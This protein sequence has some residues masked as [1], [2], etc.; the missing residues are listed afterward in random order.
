MICRGLRAAGALATLIVVAPPLGAMQQ[1]SLAE[2]PPLRTLEVVTVI[3]PDSLDR[4]TFANLVELLQARVPGLSVTR[5]GDGSALVHMRGSASI[6]ADNEP[7]LIVDGVRISLSRRRL[8][9]FVGRP[10]PLDAIDVEQIERIEVAAGPSTA[11]LYGSGAANGVITVVTRGARVMPTQWRFFTSGGALEEPNAYPANFNRPGTYAGGSPTVFCTR[12]AEARGDCTPTGPATSFNPLEDEDLLRRAPLARLGGSVASGSEML[13]WHGAATYERVGSVTSG[14]ARDRAYVRAAT[15]MRT[16]SATELSLRAHWMEGVDRLRGDFGIPM[17][18][19]AL[20]PYSGSTSWPGFTAFPEPE[21]ELSR[22]GVSLFANWRATPWLRGT[23]LTGVD[24]S[25]GRDGFEFVDTTGGATLTYVEHVRQRRNDFTG[26]ADIEATYGIGA[27]LRAR[28]TALIELAE[29]RRRDAS[30]YEA[31]S[32]SGAAEWR[33]FW[34]HADQDIA[35]LAIG[36]EI[37]HGGRGALRLALRHEDLN[38][39]G[40]GWKTPWYPHA[41]AAWVA[42]ADDDG[43][44]GGVKFHAAYGKAGA[45]PSLDHL[46]F[47]ALPLG[48]PPL[49]R[50]AEVTTER[51]LGVDASF[52]GRRADLS[53]VWYSK[54]TTDVLMDFGVLWGFGEVLNRGI[55]GSLRA[56][57]LG[58]ERASWDVRVGYA[59]NHNE[60]TNA[61]GGTLVISPAPGYQPRQVARPSAPLGAYI[62][63]PVASAV[64]ADGDGVLESVCNATEPEPCE[65]RFAPEPEFRPAFPPTEVSF[66]SALRIGSATLG[67]LIDH[68]RGHYLHNLTEGLRCD[69]TCADA[70]APSLSREDAIRLATTSVYASLTTGAFVER[71]TFTKLRELSLRVEAP[72]AWAR[73]LGASRLELSLAG[74]NLVTWTDY[75]GMDPEA[76]SYGDD[77]LVVGDFA[78]TPLPRSLSLRLTLTR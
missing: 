2:G 20:F 22:R 32:S 30:E 74:R 33:F 1:D 3:E 77:G 52:V 58:T 5:R 13:A 67:F 39:F 37:L 44:L 47:R 6:F 18:Q 14:A 71:A 51:E 54:R 36:Q 11:A 75:S 10:S 73:G 48:A 41:S 49:E 72:A 12:V 45:L 16:S 38:T 70:Y 50:K 46:L 56:R 21:H 60:L 57:L 9:E 17:R 8:E 27:S 55:Q 61:L 62:V 68:R 19:Q 15:R 78:S 63:M 53:L 29:H 64:D 35:G 40:Y 25:S 7:L 34:L 4:A 59:H 43:L 24:R 42:M 31:R 76:S 28:T 23:I 69:Y 65:V 66:E 26:R